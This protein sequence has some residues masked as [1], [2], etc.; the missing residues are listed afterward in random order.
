MQIQKGPDLK[1]PIKRNYMQ[2]SLQTALKTTCARYLLCVFFIKKK[3][4]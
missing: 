3:K 2:K 4:V 1:Q